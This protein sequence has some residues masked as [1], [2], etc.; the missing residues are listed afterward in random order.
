MKYS[1]VVEYEHIPVTCHKP[2]VTRFSLKKSLT[3]PL[4][5]EILMPH[6][7]T[8]KYQN[9]R[10]KILLTAAAAMV[11]GLVSS[12]AQ[13]YSAN[14]VGYVTYTSQTSSPK[15]EMI[16]NPLNNGSNTL[17]SVFPTPPGGTIIE[18]WNGTGFTPYTYTKLGGWGANA[19]VVVSPGQGFFI[20]VGGTGIYTNTFVG[21]VAPVTG[22]TG[23]NVIGTGFQA[24]ASEVPYS[25][26]VSNTATIDLVVPGGTIAETW[27][28]ATQ[29]FTP[30]TFVGLSKKWSPSDLQVSVGQ[31]FFLQNNSGNPINWAQTGP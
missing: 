19:S 4:L 6:T 5:F 28:P 8:T 11:A 25:G 15:F 20:S 9:M 24:V 7:V 26:S 1:E 10:T 13:V 17:G 3:P 30:Y 16:C 27:N 29:A 22:T 2:L 31:G 14:I 18:T 21:S 12:N 23:T